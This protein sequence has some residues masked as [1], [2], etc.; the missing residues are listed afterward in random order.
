MPTYGGSS[1]GRVQAPPRRARCLSWN[2]ERGELRS[3]V[4]ELLRRGGRGKDG[5]GNAGLGGRC[6]G[7]DVG[8][9]SAQESR[10][11]LDRAHVRGARAAG[12]G[13]AAPADAADP[14]APAED[15]CV[16]SS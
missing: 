14:G 2:G 5:R 13:A 1:A 4:A 7:A 11:H 15:V 12:G 6:A 9:A 10:V 8:H 3:A 16:G